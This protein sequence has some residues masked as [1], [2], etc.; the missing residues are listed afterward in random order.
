MKQLVSKLRFSNR[1]V[2]P[3]LSAL[4]PYSILSVFDKAVVY[5][6]VECSIAAISNTKL[7]TITLSFYFYNVLIITQ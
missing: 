3:I 6:N 2:S 7:V 4:Y 5:G 1:F